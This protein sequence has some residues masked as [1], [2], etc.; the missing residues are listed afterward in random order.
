[1]ELFY[2][3]KMHWPRI[4]LPSR[5][6]VLRVYADVTRRDLTRFLRADSINSLSVHVHG[7][8]PYTRS[9]LYHDRGLNLLLICDMLC[10]SRVGR[11]FDRFDDVFV[12]T[13]SVTFVSSARV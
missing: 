2:G 7:S 8:C 6:N 13:T 4:L 12:S 9:A 5:I 3:W 10:F 1:M 11:K